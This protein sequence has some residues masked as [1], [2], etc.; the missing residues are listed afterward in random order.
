MEILQEWEE[1]P[2][3]AKMYQGVEKRDSLPKRQKILKG[4]WLLKTDR[5]MEAGEARP[6]ASTKMPRSRGMETWCGQTTEDWQAWTVGI[7]MA[8]SVCLRS[9]G[10]AQLCHSN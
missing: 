7:S 9:E 6:P 2:E 5:K 10:L 3:V 4:R 1:I 8:A